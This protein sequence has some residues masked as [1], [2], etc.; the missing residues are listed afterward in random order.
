[1][2]SLAVF[3]LLALAI[4]GVGIAE[5]RFSNFESQRA[6]GR[7]HTF[8]ANPYSFES[9]RQNPAAL[10]EV[11]KSTIEFRWFALD[12]FAGENTLDTVG[13]LI[14]ASTSSDDNGLSKILDSFDDRFG[15]RQ[16]GSLQLLPIGFRWNSFVFEPF[17]TTRNLIEMRIP[18]MPQL[19]LMSDSRFG[20]NIS[21]AMMFGKSLEIGFTLRP[22]SRVFVRGEVEAT[23]AVQI[24]TS[25]N[26]TTDEYIANRTGNYTALDLGAMWIFS[27]G[28]RWGLVI[29]DV[30][31][32]AAGPDDDTP[33]NIKQT[34]STGVFFRKNFWKSWHF[35][36]TF[37]LQD[38]LLRH[39]GDG[40]RMF[41]AGLEI[42]RNYLTTDNDI[43]V[44]AGLNDGWVS[45][46]GFVDL[47][48]MRLGISNYAVEV[49]HSPG[50]RMDRRWGL[51]AQSSATF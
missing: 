6:A 24:A 1:M 3:A 46:G 41:H 33:P 31:D 48:L 26:S 35:D 47:W 43:G 38:V 15:K 9:P 17:A 44:Q 27:P 37:D 16:Y 8:V 25:K 20:A 42:G 49:G 12:I 29:H 21:Y 50:Q 30:G 2:K 22:F 5:E 23:D 13:D 39:G 18:T 19:T 14:D 40:V 11:K 36:S 45:L 32:S 34:I 28:F 4:P 7:G 10:A 51:T